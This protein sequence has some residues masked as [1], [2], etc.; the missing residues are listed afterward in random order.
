[1][2]ISFFFRTD[3]MY[4]P[5]NHSRSNRGP[6]LEFS[7][8]TE[9][10]QDA[11]DKVLK[12]NATPEDFSPL[13]RTAAEERLERLDQP[14]LGFCRQISFNTLRPGPGLGNLDSS[15]PLLLKVQQR[16]IG[17]GQAAHLREVRKLYFARAES[18]GDG[19]IR[20]P[21]INADCACGHFFSLVE[22]RCKTERPQ[23]RYSSRTPWLRTRKYVATATS[24][25]PLQTSTAGALNLL[26][27]YPLTKLPRG[28]PPRN[29]TI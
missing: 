17:I 14:A 9:I 26:A 12:R 29:A 4:G 15:L 23:Q 2:V 16:A 19:A 5:A 3:K 21:K 27:K 8:F 28:M 13:E 18:M 7:F 11:G 1:M 24:R 25:M 6:K 20:S 22:L 10:A